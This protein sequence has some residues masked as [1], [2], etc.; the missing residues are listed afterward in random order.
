MSKEL[1]TISDADLL[2]IVEEIVTQEETIAKSMVESDEEKKKKATAAAAS[3]ESAPAESAEKPTEPKDESTPT[4]S[5]EAPKAQSEA[6]AA[7]AE[8]EVEKSSAGNVST[9][10]DGG[11]P[12]DGPGPGASEDAVKAKKKSDK[13][14][15][16]VDGTLPEAGGGA[17][18][19]SEDSANPKSEGGFIAKSQVEIM[20]KFMKSL[21]TVAGAVKTLTEKVADLEVKTAEEMKKSTTAS[22]EFRKSVTVEIA[23]RLSKSYHKEVEEL[24]K[25][26]SAVIQETEALRKS[27][28]QFKTSNEALK[29]ESEELRKS[30]KKP[31]DTR[32]SIRGI[33]AIEKSTEE[34][35]GRTFST[36]NEVCDALEEL[37]K[38]GKV[39]GDEVISYNVSN[40]L[41]PNAKRQLQ[42]S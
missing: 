1:Q 5:S 3:S 35:A 14:L 6:A 27:N 38:S 34:K 32:A 40:I 37:R 13:D 33:D 24:R 11:Q 28:D 25:A 29:A 12:E 36:K 9:P 30:L 22:D 16:A 10:A 41:S 20:E 4:E 26:N 8:S 31:A 17:T 2:N 42:K 18:G 19:G 23:E 15:G 21:E 7:P 39:S